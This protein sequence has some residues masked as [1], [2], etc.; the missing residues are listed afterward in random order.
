MATPV[1]TNPDGA[2]VEMRAYNGVDDQ[3]LAIGRAPIAAATGAPAGQVRWRISKEGYE[4]L[5]ASP[6]A[7]PYEFR[8]TPSKEITSGMV[9]VPGGEFSLESTGQTVKL[10]DFWIDRFEVTNRAFKQF[11]DA[12]GYQKREYWATPFI[13]DGRTIDWPEAMSRFRDTTGRA[14]P[15]T[16][17]LGAYPDGQADY[18]V[19]GVSWYEAAAYAAFAGKSLPTAYHWYCASGAFGIF[20]S[21]V[22]FSNFGGKGPAAVGLSRGSVRSAPTTWRATSRNG[23]GTRPI[24]D[25]AM[26]SA[27][28]TTR[29]PTSSGTRMPVRQWS[30]APRSASA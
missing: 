23:A 15:S 25:G 10:P 4:T 22:G 12:G 27:A 8:L 16:W 19:G 7:P 6:S 11:V 17:E 1:R 2:L 21:I 14:G 24:V 28:A 29:R 3:W 30:E 5:E 9:F 18:P 26:C 13:A 20:S